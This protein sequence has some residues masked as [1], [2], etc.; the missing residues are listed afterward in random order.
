VSCGLSFPCCVLGLTFWE[1]V[2]LTRPCHDGTTLPFLASTQTYLF[3]AAVVL[4]QSMGCW[5]SRLTVLVLALGDLRNH[6]R[7]QGLVNILFLRNVGN[8]AHC[9]SKRATFAIFVCRFY[10][11]R[12]HFQ[13]IDVFLHT[14]SVGEF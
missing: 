4:F 10:I 9:L 5:K 12:K 14:S 8:I 6:P 1:G 7:H 2:P 3:S 11:L 13:I